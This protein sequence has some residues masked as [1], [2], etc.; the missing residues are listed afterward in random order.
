MLHHNNKSAPFLSVNLTFAPV[1]LAPRSLVMV[2]H[3]ES[4]ANVIA[5]A[6][7]RGELSEFPDSF[8]ELSDREIPLTQTGR[9]QAS[10]IGAALRERYPL[11]FD[12]ILSSDYLRARETAELIRN[13]AGWLHTEMVVEPLVGERNWGALMR[14]RPEDFLNIGVSMWQDPL[15]FRPPEGETIRETMERA[16]SFFRQYHAALTEK[17]VLLVSH[18]EFIHSVCAELAGWDESHHEEVLRNGES[19]VRNCQVI[20]FGSE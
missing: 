6:I 8:K 9:E 7:R 19:K 16:R 5:R 12:L 18:G 10:N 14:L 11:G 13:A 15:G 17:R 1:R 3:G 4:V 20:E 2:R